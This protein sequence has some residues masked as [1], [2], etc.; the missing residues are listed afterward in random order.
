MCSDRTIELFCIFVFVQLY[1]A[2]S[3]NH[4]CVYQLS[5]SFANK[6]GVRCVPGFV[7]MHPYTC[8][9]GCVRTQTDMYLCGVY[10]PTKLGAKSLTLLPC[11]KPKVCPSPALVPNVM[12]TQWA[13]RAHRGCPPRTPAPLTRAILFFSSPK[14]NQPK[15]FWKIS[16]L[17]LFLFLVLVFE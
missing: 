5:F 9:I 6:A 17:F 11:S 2:K 12:W 15:D 4:C 14:A 7:S 10:L 3:C 1:S 16:L 8:V 13:G